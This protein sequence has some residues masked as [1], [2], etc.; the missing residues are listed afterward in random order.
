MVYYTR[1]RQDSYCTM[2]VFTKT[3]QIQ[4]KIFTIDTLIGG[5]GVYIRRP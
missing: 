5:E 2:Y 1:I 3:C 4:S